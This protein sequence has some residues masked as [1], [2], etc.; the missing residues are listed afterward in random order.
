MRI[1]I[2][3]A[4]T[5]PILSCE[6]N[7]DSKETINLPMETKNYR[8]LIKFKI[9]P[10][11]GAGEI[12]AE[13]D[14]VELLKNIPYMFSSGVVPSLNIINDVLA[15]GRIDAGMSGD[16]TWEP[17]QLDAS[18]FGEFVA[19][20]KASD[21]HESLEY[22][23]PDSWVNGFDD[24]NVWVMYLKKGIPWEQ[25]KKLNDIVISLE[26]EMKQAKADGNDQRVNELHIE[27][28]KSGTKLAEFVMENQQ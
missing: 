12:E 4:I 24:W 8:E 20:L 26:Q 11:V 14:T 5:M 27:I 23:E 18:G 16:A 21:I 2:I 28:I 6:N 22:I 19:Q 17:Y 25:H 1:L 13:G 9:L 7:Y 15:I 3:A 10:P